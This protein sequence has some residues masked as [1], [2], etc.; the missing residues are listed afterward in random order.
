MSRLWFHVC[1]S[2]VIEIKYKMG[3]EMVET[4]K[5]HMLISVHEIDNKSIISL[6]KSLKIESP[7]PIR[8]DRNQ[9]CVVQK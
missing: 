1:I 7:F 4:K 3:G 6:K 5:C 9:K 2:T 8:S